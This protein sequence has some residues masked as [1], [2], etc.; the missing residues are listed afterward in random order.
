MDRFLTRPRTGSLAMSVLAT[1]V[2]APAVLAAEPAGISWSSPVDIHDGGSVQLQDADFLKSDV[3]AVWQEQEPSGPIVRLRS[4][5]DGGSTFGPTLLIEEARQSAVDI[6]SG[7]ELNAIWSRQVTPGN[8]VIQ[9]AVGQTNGEGYGVGTV[10]PGPGVSR[11]PDISCAGGRIFTAWFQR[12]GAKDRI[13]VAHATRSSG[14]FSPPMS[15]GLYDPDPGRGR[16]LAVA[17][18]ND[19]A[20]VAFTRTDGTLR[21][22]RWSVGAGPG[23][24]V[25]AMGTSVIGPGTPED[26][27]DQAV[28]DARG[29]K[30][31]LAWFKCGGIQARVS[32]DRGDTW[33]PVHEVAPH[34]ACDGDF[35]TSPRSIAIRG[36]RIAITYLASEINGPGSVRLITTTSDFVDYSD[37]LVAAE[38]HDEHVVGYQRVGGIVR[39]GAVFDPGNSIRFRRQI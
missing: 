33:G 10:A 19:T 11:F 12:E 16:S 34:V 26:S 22:R 27:A 24:A 13:Q 4:S 15:L 1:A 36:E 6:C 38:T 39:L 29:D 37:A 5:T 30:V 28:I 17:G 7:N 23:F 20:Y 35:A 32:N 25:A 2:M 14:A 21:L 9:Y 31:A 8:W 18:V 3:S